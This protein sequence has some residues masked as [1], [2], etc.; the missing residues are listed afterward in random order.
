MRRETSY[1]NGIFEVIKGTGLALALSLVWTVIFANV[2]RFSPLSDKW[3]YPLNQ[4]WKG[5]AV[6]IATLVCVRGEQGILKGLGIGVLFSF[7]S[8]LTFSA[9]GGDF[10]LSWWIVIEL[11]LTAL[12]GVICGALA[13]SLKKSG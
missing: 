8:Y 9:I 3:V 11:L 4:T 10:S 12:I 2:L 1:G 7:L 13:V 5:V 6:C